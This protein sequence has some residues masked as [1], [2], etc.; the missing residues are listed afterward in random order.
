M[1]RTDHPSGT[2]RLAEVARARGWAAGEVI[3]NVQGDEPLLAPANVD[4]VAALLHAHA[5]ADLAT[6]GTPIASLQ[7]FVDP[8]VVKIALGA[9][10][11][12]LYFSRAPIPWPR[13][14]AATG[15]ASQTQF[16][17]ALRHLGLY[18]YRC[19]AL[20]RIAALP[21]SPLECAERLEQLRALEHG[22]SVRVATAVE[23][24]GPSVD[25]ESDLEAAAAALRARGS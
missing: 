10:G 21:P 1:T 14:S 15:L 20:L 25:T 4:Q 9:D 22:M 17:S 16:G 19:A 3:V 7:E 23:V 6:L 11:R 13:D 24:P 18:A 12:A 8:N 2:D 5:D